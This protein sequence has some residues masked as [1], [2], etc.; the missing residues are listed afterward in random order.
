LPEEEEEVDPWG[1]ISS[2]EI[3][4]KIRIHFNVPES[5][6]DEDILK[7]GESLFSV[8][9]H[10]YHVVVGNEIE[11][12]NIRKDF[13]RLAEHKRYDQYIIAEPDKFLAMT[14]RL[15]NDGFYL[16][17]CIA[18]RFTLERFLHY[19]LMETKEFGP[20]I[21]DKKKNPSIQKMIDFISNRDSWD[22]EFKKKI[23][24]IKE[25][26][27]W[28][29]HHRFDKIFEGMTEKDFTWSVAR[30]T[31]G[32]DGLKTEYDEWSTHV[33]NRDMKSREYVYLSI[34]YLHE[35]FYEYRKDLVPG[36]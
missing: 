24:M 2:D 29:A 10:N 23:E 8:L 31:T 14:E 21:K 19:E 34:E 5:M 32:F 30:A 12:R 22:P 26:G 25:H 16:M 18:G 4:K 15:F 17:A 35:L 36:E 33:E 9:V 11:L 7:I 20:T 3:I 6:T 1:V 13:V 27:D 28:Q